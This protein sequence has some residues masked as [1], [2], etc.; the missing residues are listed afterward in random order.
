MNLTSPAGEDAQRTDSALLGLANDHGPILQQLSE[1]VIIARLDGKLMFVNQAAERLHGVKTL[2]VGPD[3]Y[4]KTYH[5][6]T[7][8]GEPYPYADLPLVKAV[9]DG[10]TVDDARWRIRRPDGSEVVAIGSA[11]PL[12]RD[13][14]QIGAI[15]NVRDDT[16]RF[17]ADQRLRLN[18]ERM[19]LI[20]DAATDYAIFTTDPA[21]IVTSWSKGAA[22][23][24]GYS[25]DEAIGMNADILWTPEDRDHAQPVREV[26]TARANGCANDERWHQRSDGSRVFLNGSAH[27]L[28]L[29][30][31][32][33]ERGFIKIARDETESRAA[34][35][36][37]RESGAQL[38]LALDSAAS[39]FYSVDRQGNTTLVSRGFL[40]MMGFE[41]ESDVVGQKLHSVIHHTHPDGS[42]YSVEQCPIYQCA[43]VG[44]PAHVPKELFFRPDGSE[45]PVEYWVAPIMRDGEHVGA[46]C[47]ILDLTERMI[48]DAALRESE[49]RFRN[50]ADHA[51]VMMW[52]TEPDG[53]CT[54]LNRGWYDFTGQT[55]EEALG[56]GWLK[57]VH[58]DDAAEAERVFVEANASAM[59]FRVEYRLRRA[60]GIYRWAID[61]ASPRFGANGQRLGFVGSVV[62]IDERKLVEQ[63]LQAKS[64]EFYTLADNIP[65]LAWIAYADGN[66]FW[67][68]RRWYEFTGTTAE[69]Q[70]GWGWESVHDPEVLPSVIERWKHSLSTGE[71][72]DMTF[73]LRG[74]DGA[75]RLFL[76][77]VVPIRD[78]QGEI[79]RWF[80]TNVDV[81]A[82]VEAD[83]RRQFTLDLA[84]RLGAL[85]NPR[86][87][88][89]AAVEVLGRHLGVTRVGFGE[90]SSDDKSVTFETDYADGVAHLVGTF[91]IENFG[92]GNM[93]AL[94]RGITTIYADVTADPRTS[95]ADW[96]V[97]A[98][99][100]ALAV[101]LLRDGRMSALLYL[102]HNEV[103][104][105][106]P[107]EV[108][109]A[110]DVAARTRDALERARA[111]TELQ[112]LNAT[113]EARIEQ[114]TERRAA[115]EGALHQSQKMETLGQLTGGIAHD[116]NNL[117][118]IITGNLDILRRTIPKD[119]PRLHRSVENAFKGAERAAILT[120]R[121][122]AFSRR[123]PLAP[124]V[125]NPNKLVTGMSELL[126]RAIGETV[127]VETVL[128]SGLWRVEADPNQLENALLNL[129]VNA[130]D[131]MPDGGK[132]TIETAN[133][134][135]DRSYAEQ[136]SGVAPGQYVVICVSDTGSGM[137]AGTAERAFDPFFTTKEVGKGTGLGLSMV[138]GF[139]K[140]SGG[141]LKIY[142]ELG[143]GTTVRIYLP[144]HHG[145]EVEV[146]TK[147]ATDF[148]PAASQGETILVCEDDDDVRAY[149]AQSLRELG[150]Q[151][152]EAADG[153]S[154]LRLLEKADGTVD[155]LFTDIVLPGGMTGAIVAE[156]ARQI[157]P[158]LKVLFTTGYARNAIVHHGRLDAGV[159]LLSK[160][161]SYADLAARVREMLDAPNEQGK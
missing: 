86:D 21:R 81:S 67:Y 78:E 17:E 54:Y 130:R 74:L 82:Q 113:L 151:V 72:F 152:I 29:D 73:P 124:K 64:E 22:T 62:D 110:Q 40:D 20:L 102:N 38:R 140:Q 52:V 5:L 120:Q 107:H 32:G 153:H 122:L 69:T 28:P 50:V 89:A 127:A 99:R 65:A 96:E 25:A 45:V 33:R 55:E 126:F 87:I 92:R 8:D 106:L 57:A 3:D 108:A 70:A 144:R 77:R 98:T 135:V 44:T 150:Y 132:L 133:T 123:Q 156:K 66:I 37:M 91:P 117:L 134:H 48:T 137:D 11:R 42:H 111:E 84:D 147:L 43:A 36:S 101:P 90:M 100:A 2:D 75:F 116:F 118:Q 23:V 149:S 68:N 129:A 39:A 161:F 121:L 104:E 139:V 103:R 61:A 125:F 160:P 71:P 138:Y 30:P 18:E 46:I 112:Q 19:R 63:A 47:T 35:E 83:Q 4:S 58:P 27:P 51:P 142:S 26:E 141:H 59:P 34:N 145:Q 154:A 128:G 24:F 79:V 94:A 97:I 157:Q 31:Q 88:V 1:G 16:A 56:F 60:D 131:A 136:N 105:W 14:R 155:L 95:D 41:H 159:E 158:Q 76:T 85:A 9:R 49:A 53:H 109:L 114:E 146:E 13:G 93:D 119:S 143:E 10:A 7:M 6:F 80:G 115:A 12:I 148:A 15:L